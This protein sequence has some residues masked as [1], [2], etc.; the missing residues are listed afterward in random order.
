[1][2]RSRRVVESKS[3]R[4]FH[5]PAGIA[6]E[7]EGNGRERADSGAVQVKATRELTV[8]P[9]GYG[10]R[11]PVQPGRSRTVERDSGQ[12][13]EFKP[14]EPTR[15]VRREVHSREILQRDVG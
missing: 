13:P 2:H 4:R 12:V 3:R 8:N 11:G 5:G 10:S 1:M 7:L 15:T 14:I 9:V 6:D